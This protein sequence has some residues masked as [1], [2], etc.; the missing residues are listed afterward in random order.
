MTYKHNNPILL[1]QFL[2]TDTRRDGKQL[3]VDILCVDGDTGCFLRHEPHSRCVVWVSNY[4]Y[5]DKRFPYVKS[6]M[7]TIRLS[8]EKVKCF[9][10]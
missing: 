1:L 7:W 10:N 4:T 2:F 8:G 5:F 9:V 3:G 6:L